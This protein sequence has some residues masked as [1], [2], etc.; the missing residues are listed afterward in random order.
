ME[1][2]LSWD[3]EDLDKRRP[4]IFG[5]AISG[6]IFVHPNTGGAMYEPQQGQYVAIHPITRITGEK[7]HNH[8]SDKSY[9]STLYIT[10]GI[11]TTMLYLLETMEEVQRK[12]SGQTVPGELM[13]EKENE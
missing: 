4:R 3:Q 6:F 2:K 8:A 10:E 9:F 12:M 13:K 1:T 11:H 5:P 7:P